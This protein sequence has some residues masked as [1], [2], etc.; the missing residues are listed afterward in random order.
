MSLAVSEA[1]PARLRPCAKFGFDPHLQ[2]GAVAIATEVQHPPAGSTLGRPVSRRNFIVWYLASL[3]TA[4]VV[5]ALGPLLVYI[6]PPAGSNKKQSLPVTL[7]KALTDLGNGEATQFDAPKG[8]AFV[9]VSDYPG[10][11]N[12]AGDPAFS[13]F[14]VKD[15][16]G[17]LNVFAVNCSHL[18]CSVSFNGGAK[19]FDCPCHG[20][21]FHIDGTVLHGPATAPLSKLS[22][23]QG[24]SPA[25]IIVQGISMPGL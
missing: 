19:E 16:Q 2:T 5:A 21:K 15:E 25:E 8:S 24:S 9:M 4:L 13:G 20:S 14:A 23:K 10:S 17:Q 1:G 18:G 3:M 22:W 7:K 11:D 6:Y 12:A